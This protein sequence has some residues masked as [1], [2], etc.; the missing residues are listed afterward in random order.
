MRKRHHVVSEGYLRFFADGRRILLCEKFA[1]TA[2]VVG[3]GDAFVSKHFNTIFAD[4]HR[5]DQLEDKWQS[6]ESDCLPRV[7]A[8][9]SGER[10]DEQRW[11]VRVLGAR[12]TGTRSG[13]I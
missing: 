2:K 9:L 11:A 5:L 8:L 13:V 1:R 12:V 6:L 3:T 7:R 10:G 4:D